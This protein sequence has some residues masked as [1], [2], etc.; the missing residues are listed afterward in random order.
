MCDDHFHDIDDSSNDFKNYMFI[1]R[2]T[3][4]ITTSDSLNGLFK[5]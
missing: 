4:L 5:I 2:A 3:P 1:D